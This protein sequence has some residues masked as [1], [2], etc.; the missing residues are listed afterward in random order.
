MISMLGI[1]IIVVVALFLPW[2]FAVSDLLKSDLKGNDRLTL[3]LL[4]G[5]PVIGPIMY[6]TQGK[7]MK[8]S[9]DR[10]DK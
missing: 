5:I 4:V 7:K 8:K 2:F 3:F 1:V 9:V 10:E 6:F